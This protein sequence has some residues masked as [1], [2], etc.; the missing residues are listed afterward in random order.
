MKQTAQK[1]FLDTHLQVTDGKRP[2]L[3]LVSNAF[4]DDEH[5]GN[6]ACPELRTS[7]KSLSDDFVSYAKMNMTPEQRDLAIKEITLFA[8]KLADR[9]N[10]YP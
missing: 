8:K 7:L 5:L 2:R 4:I 1:T 9:L 6:T 3:L 10:E